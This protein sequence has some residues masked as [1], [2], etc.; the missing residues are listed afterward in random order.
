MPPPD[1]L[2]SVTTSPVRTEA[3]AVSGLQQLVHQQARLTYASS[4]LDIGIW[5]HRGLPKLECSCHCNLLNLGSFVGVCLGLGGGVQVHVYGYKD[6]RTVLSV[7][8]LDTI[9]LSLPPQLWNYRCPTSHSL[10]NY[11]LCGFWNSN[12]VSASLRSKQTYYCSSP[13]G[14]ANMQLKFR[15]KNLAQKSQSKKDGTVQ[16][17]LKHTNGVLMYV[18]GCRCA[19]VFILES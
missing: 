4:S 7:G 14:R 11:C 8:S 16:R 18:R 6:Q 5:G 13:L 1:P 17:G 15:L 9:F 12:S 10:F 19:T 3:H 2:T